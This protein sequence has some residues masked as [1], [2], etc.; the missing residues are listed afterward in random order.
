MTDA[1]AAT[2]VGMHVGDAL[3]VIQHRE[4]QRFERTFHDGQLT[5]IPKG[6]RTTCTTMG[7]TSFVHLHFEA[8][9]H[10]ELCDGSEALTDGLPHR[11][12]FEDRS[13][14]RHLRNLAAA[15]RAPG[16]DTSLLFESSAL[17]IWSR[18][19]RKAPPTGS[20]SLGP[21]AL[22]RAKELLHE[23]ISGHVSL[24]SL[25]EAAR[26]SPRHFARLFARATGRSPHQY[27]LEIRM[28]KAKEL[29]E[30]PDARVID[31]AAAVG[32]ANPSHFTEAFTRLIS[33]SPSRYRAARAPRVPETQSASVEARPSNG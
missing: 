12:A 27:L 2:V 23:S 6:M 8:G 1:P 30:R 14:A 31:V 25:A 4:D 29:L 7:H 20:S 11:F 22:A 16:P 33:V 21:R 18:L 32:Y 3:K 9:F 10:S 17:A 13:V 19:S 26:L 24:A 15:A 5:V 28:E